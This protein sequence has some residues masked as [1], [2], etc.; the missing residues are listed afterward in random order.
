MSSTN[1][2]KLLAFILASAVLLS[3]AAP[4]ALAAEEKTAAHVGPDITVMLG[5]AGGKVGN[6]NVYLDS[7]LAGKTDLWG[8]FTFKEAPAAGNHTVTVSAKDLKNVTVDTSFAEKPVAIKTEMSKG[9]NMTIHV[10]DKAG[11]Q[12][13]AGVSAINWDYNMGT[14]DASG[15]LVIKDCPAGI[16]LI[17]LEKDGFKTTTTLLIVYSNRTQNYSLTQAK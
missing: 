9:N 15:D 14:T 13:I 6:M 5:S 1:R 2:F 17:K 10:T 4:I 7:K 8:N 16:Y 3:M 12:G 11:K